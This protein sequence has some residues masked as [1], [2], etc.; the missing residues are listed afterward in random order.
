MTAAD[1]DLAVNR[2]LAAQRVATI[3]ELID[4]LAPSVDV[5]RKARVRLAGSYGFAA[6]SLEDVRTVIDDLTRPP[7]EELTP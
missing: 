3:L 7:T 4:E 5:A 6:A 1:E 2:R